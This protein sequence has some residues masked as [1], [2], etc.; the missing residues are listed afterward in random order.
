MNKKFFLQLL[1]AIFIG[2]LCGAIVG[3]YINNQQSYRPFEF[4][5]GVRHSGSGYVT[6]ISH[7]L[8]NE[9]NYDL[10]E[11][12]QKIYSE[13]VLMN[14]NHD[15]IVFYLYDSL[16]ALHNSQHFSTKIYIKGSD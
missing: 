6:S 15:E 11:L 13:F 3:G 5:G 4:R 1:I 16:E 12:Y 7:V 8:I 10:E 9:E 2:G 14:G